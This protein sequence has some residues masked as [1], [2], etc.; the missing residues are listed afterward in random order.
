MDADKRMKLIEEIAQKIERIFDECLTP[1]EDEFEML[2][3]ILGVANLMDERYSDIA[4]G[5]IK[6]KGGNLNDSEESD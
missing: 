3:V 4:D 5:W 6:R 2:C 1:C